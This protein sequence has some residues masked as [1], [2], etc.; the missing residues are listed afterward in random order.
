MTDQGF[1]ASRLPAAPVARAVP[2]GALP[3]LPAELLVP[4]VPDLI[5]GLAHPDVAT[6]D[7]YAMDWIREWNLVPD[8]GQLEILT[9]SHFG[10]FAAYTFPRST[11]LDLMTGWTV[12][13]WLIDDQFDDPKVPG[14]IAFARGILSQFDTPDRVASP[15]SQLERA[16]S[17]L[18]ARTASGMSA[19]WRMRARI[20]VRDYFS[21][22]LNSSRVQ[23]IS[24]VSS[25]TR[26]RRQYSGVAFF[27]DLLE[28]AN[29]YELPTEITGSDLYRA[30]REHAND[31]ISWANDLHS[32]RRDAAAGCLEN[33]V[34]VLA[35]E[36]GLGWTEAFGRAVAMIHS[37]TSETI[38]ARAEMSAVR[39]FSSLPEWDTVERSLD[40][41]TIW[42]A[43]NVRWHRETSRYSQN[44]G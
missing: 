26:R 36:D 28:P 43:G 7:A 38:S 31:A 27:L 16:T 12:W 6:A 20:A 11:D 15:S 2:V 40:D 39:E 14:K 29:G 30:V 10:R 22:T 4:E 3:A 24:N 8:P 18:W 37:A 21:A 33:L 34:S 13:A 41:V 23:T 1:Q 17:D 25:Y 42:I 44:I 35:C 5:S 9:H 19:A 32:V